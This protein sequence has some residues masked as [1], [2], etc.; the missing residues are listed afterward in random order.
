MESGDM[1]KF[2][3]EID[4]QDGRI[5]IL[6]NENKDLQEEVF[7]LKQEVKSKKAEYENLQERMHSMSQHKKNVEQE[8]K[9]TQ[10]L[11][12]AVM[13]ENTTENHLIKVASGQKERL[14]QEITKTEKEK[15]DVKEKI[16]QDENL[17][18]KVSEEI[19]KLRNELN[20]DKKKL[21]EWLAL[22]AEKDDD[23]MTF[24]KYKRIDETKVNELNLQINY[25]LEEVRKQKYNL[26]VEVTETQSVQIAL[27]KTAEEFRR[28]H[29]ERHELIERWQRTLSLMRKRDMDMDNLNHRIHLLNI[30]IAKKE[31]NIAEKKRF[32]E[33]E[34]ENNRQ[35]LENIRETNK[36]ASKL[37]HE[38]TEKEEQ[39]IQFANELEA[40]QRTVDRTATDLEACRTQVLELKKETQKANERNEQSDEKV[41]ELKKKVEVID[42]LS[43]T[44]KEAADQIEL[45]LSREEK[46]RDR[47]E[48]ELRDLR[49]LK[50]RKEQELKVAQ[51]ELK[52]LEI[53][54]GNSRL[55]V[56]NMENKIYR[57]D[58][59]ALKQEALLYSQEVAIDG[60]NKR[61]SN[62]EGELDLDE[63]TQKKTELKVLT[64][65]LDEKN[66]TQKMLEV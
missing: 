41:N 60:L 54:T 45:L 13:K 22:T 46:E 56:R 52:V 29:I 49:S 16:N 64:E 19:D 11:I 8:L 28:T 17:R 58:Q 2:L 5:P 44:S 25:L 34:A 27:D 6:N 59:D 66:A 38:Y 36:S 50:F 63:L 42:K 53:K 20:L 12:L 21:E 40:L 30:G 7:R 61:I 24:Q 55:A 1:E 14:Y 32:Y 65:T 62:M 26:D 33:N 31:R 48:S 3:C 51:D 43:M 9:N 10:D 4:W 39:R 18:F 35:L 15:N 57:L 37:R 23:F 47:Q